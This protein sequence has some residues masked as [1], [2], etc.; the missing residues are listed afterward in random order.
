MDTNKAQTI[1]DVDRFYGCKV[2]VV[3]GASKDETHYHHLDEN[4]DNWFFENVVPLAA[5]LNEAI[6]THRKRTTGK[7]WPP[8]IDDNLRPGK[9]LD[10]AI[11]HLSHHNRSSSYGCSRLASFIAIRYEVQMEDLAARCAEHSLYSARPTGHLCLAADTLKRTILDGIFKRNL[12]TVNAVSWAELVKEIGCYYLEFGLPRAWSRCEDLTERLIANNESRE[13]VILKLR[14]RQHHAFVL[15]KRGKLSEGSDQLEEITE[16]MVQIKYPTGPANN[17][18]H[19]MAAQIT[20]ENIDGALA[21]LEAVK[22]K[23]GPIGELDHRVV[24]SGVPLNDG[25]VTLWTQ[26]GF[27]FRQ[28]DLMLLQGAQYKDDAFSIVRNALLIGEISGI[29][30]TGM[31]PSKALKVYMSE[32]PKLDLCHRCSE[33]GFRFFEYANNILERVERR[34]V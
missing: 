24:G 18:Q 34:V 5:G 22:K 15:L 16:R 28:A 4:S 10:A 13:A 9:L 3:S 21:T 23:I 12:E 2:C 20:A 29:S 17:L 26:R 8:A 32:H 19:Y 30:E 25:R 6:D 1:R 7:K 31:L 14:T 27:L 11:S 33:D